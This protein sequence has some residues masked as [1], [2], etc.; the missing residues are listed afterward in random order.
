M[1]MGMND[2]VGLTPDAKAPRGTSITASLS[3]D[4]KQKRAG[5]AQRRE[6]GGSVTEVM[7]FQ[8]V[9]KVWMESSTERFATTIK[10]NG[11]KKKSGEHERKQSLHRSTFLTHNAMQSR[12][13]FNLRC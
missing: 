12:A 4:M 9:W 8:E 10:D 11:G 6:R 5:G 3:A 1:W 2:S 13:L 7:I